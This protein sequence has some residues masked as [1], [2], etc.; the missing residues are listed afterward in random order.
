[1]EAR[2]TERRDHGLGHASAAEHGEGV[3]H[4]DLVVGQELGDGEVVG[5]VGA[6][7]SVGVHDGVHRPDLLGR[8]VHSVHELDACLLVGAP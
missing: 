8:G 2:V 3:I 7:L 4:R 1:M 5:V 6:Q